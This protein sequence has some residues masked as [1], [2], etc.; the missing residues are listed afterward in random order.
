ML[1]AAFD[2]LMLLREDLRDLKPYQ[3][4]HCPGTIKLDANENPYPF[5]PQ[6]LAEISRALSQVDFPVYPDPAAEELST[7]AAQYAGVKRE[8]VLMGNG[9][10]E[11]ILNLALAF[12]S[13]SKVVIAEPTFSMYRIHSQI[14]GAEAVKVPRNEDFGINPAVMIMAAR[15]TKAKLMFLCSPNNP[16]G[17]AT[18]LSAIEEILANTNAIVV[19]DQAYLEFGGEDCVPLLK[20]YP[21]LVILRTFSKAFGLAGLRVGYLLASPETVNV[22]LRVKQPYN[23]NS[24]SQSAARI[25]LKYQAEF[26]KQ[27]LQIKADREEVK[28]AL[29]DL[30]G[31]TVYPSEAN[32]LLLRTERDNGLI[33]RRLTDQGILV[34]NMG[35]SMPGCLRISIGTTAQNEALLKA[36]ETIFA[37]EVK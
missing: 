25:V 15:A 31:V 34:R 16:T 36:M 21:N 13:G 35:E 33:H 6:V 27:W 28:K 23:L 5:P 2:P 12:G 14:A 32:F 30:P 11:L 9:S 19:V 18:P 8:Q 26:A 4:H 1:N 17:N 29:A 3:P 10:D 22:L 24:F 20:K 37:N 7:A